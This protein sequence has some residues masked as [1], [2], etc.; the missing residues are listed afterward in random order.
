MMNSARKENAGVE[1]KDAT[2]LYNALRQHWICSD[3]GAIQ[4]GNEPS[5]LRVSGAPY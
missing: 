4:C 1:F 5:A 2:I 3:D